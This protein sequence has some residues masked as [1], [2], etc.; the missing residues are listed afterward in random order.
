M[1]ESQRVKTVRKHFNLNQKEFAIEIGTV[2]SKIST[3]EQGT[4]SLSLEMAGMIVEKFRVNAE[5]LMGKVGYDNTIMF[6]KDFVPKEEY[7]KVNQEKIELM[8]ELLKYKTQEIKEL[9]TVNSGV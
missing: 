1:S 3:I 9:K 7:D 4:Q 2:Q 8:E 5:W 6:A